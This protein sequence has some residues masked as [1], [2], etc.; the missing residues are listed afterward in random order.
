[1]LRI[2]MHYRR[3]IFMKHFEF[4]EVTQI[5]FELH[6]P[7][8]TVKSWLFRARAELRKELAVGLR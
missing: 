2:P 6:K 4:K 3:I 5:A 1:M 7:E 8:G